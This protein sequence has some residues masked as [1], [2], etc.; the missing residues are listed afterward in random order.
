MSE[1]E[2]LVKALRTCA[3]GHCTEQDEDNTCPWSCGD[4]TCLT[5]QQE[6]AAA[7][8][9]RLSARVAELEAAQRWIP[10][11]ER[12]PAVSEYRNGDKFK[13]MDSNELVP[14]LV[15]CED[16]EIPFRAIYDGKNW[17]DGWS[18]QEVTHWKPLPKP[19]EEEK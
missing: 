15:C 2:E 13:S 6:A 7:A 11:A 10:C 19:P 9:E 17:G 18:K 12:L 8:I 3:G 1:D 14:F 5:K 4:A 16:T